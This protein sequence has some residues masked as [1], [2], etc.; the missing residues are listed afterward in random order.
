MKS[1]AY[2]TAG[3]FGTFST[4]SIYRGDEKYY[5]NFL[6]PLIHKLNPETSHNVAVLASKYGLIPRTQYEDPMTLVRICLISMLEL[7]YFYFPPSS[8]LV[9]L[10]FCPVGLSLL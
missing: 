7:I 2:V 8:H 5:D 9:Y 4:I 6:M 3:A 1:M 10:C